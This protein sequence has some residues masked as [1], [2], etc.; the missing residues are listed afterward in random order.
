MNDVMQNT[1]KPA[2]WTWYIV[3]CAFMALMYFVVMLAGVLILFFLSKEDPDMPVNI[4]MGVL[5]MFLGLLFMVVYAIGPFFPKA[6]W[7]WIY[8]M[9]LIGI[10]MTSICCLPASIPLLIFWLKPETKRFFNMAA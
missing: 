3:Y 1:V 6:K 8:G 2:V 5:Y 10:G 9:V 4:I 7:S